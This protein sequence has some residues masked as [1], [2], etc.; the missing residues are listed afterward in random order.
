[1][2]QTTLTEFNGAELAAMTDDDLR[3]EWLPMLG[4]IGWVVLGWSHLLSG[5]PRAGKTELLIRVVRGWLEQGVR[6]V[7]LS[8]EPRSMWALRL[9]TLGGDWSGLQI[10]CG[11]G[12]DPELLLE[13]AVYGPEQAVVVD[14][15]R[16]LLRIQ[17]E[18]DNSEVA[19]VVNPWTAAARAAGKTL[20]MVHHQRKGGGDHGEGISGAHAL[21]GSFD[22]AIELK[23]DPLHPDR[24]LLESHPRLVDRQ[25][26]VYEKRG[27][28]FVILGEPHALGAEELKR[29]VFDEL[30]IAPQPTKAILEAMGDPV[31]A[32]EAVRKALLQLAESGRILREP[33]ISLSDVRGRTVRWSLPTSRHA[34]PHLPQ[35]NG[36][37]SLV[38]TPRPTEFDQPNFPPLKGEWE[39]R[40]VSTTQCHRRGERRS[41]AKRPSRQR[42]DRSRGSERWS[43]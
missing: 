24:R 43:G 23:F 33:D 3:F 35:E 19:R 1:M 36:V 30:S 28:D 39:V 9:R 16:N 32:L 29:R 40:L 6:V 14:T 13:R 38:A 27:L 17:D 34:Q 26:V 10:V 7:L 12:A 4:L 11:L 41:T 42:G 22:I 8:E 37:V 25:E 18:K 15:L 2:T 21:L 20:V 5:Y 31:P